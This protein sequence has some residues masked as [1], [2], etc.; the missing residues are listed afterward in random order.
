MTFCSPSVTDA[1][2]R[3][4]GKSLSSVTTRERYALFWWS[5]G[6]VK[7]WRTKYRCSDGH[8]VL[9]NHEGQNNVSLTIVR[10]C[11]AMK[12]KTTL[13]WRFFCVVKPSRAKERYPDDREVSR[14]YERQ[15]NVIL[16]IT[17]CHEA[18]KDK[19]TLSW[20]SCGVVKTCRTKQR[21]SRCRLVLWSHVARDDVALT[22]VQCRGGSSNQPPVSEDNEIH[23]LNSFACTKLYAEAGKLSKE[24]AVHVVLTEFVVNPCRT[25]RRC[26]DGC[27]MSWD[28]EGQTDVLTIVWSR[29]TIKDKPTLF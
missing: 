10:C 16:T 27:V 29:E 17:W 20:R 12:V 24:V 23:I 15:N 18:M 21:C 26:S 6:G 22:V 14:S 13:F 19:T 3:K 2:V 25:N 5:C 7:P 1:D 8:V 9:R 11:E 28:N 4:N